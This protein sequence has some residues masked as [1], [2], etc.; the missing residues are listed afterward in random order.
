MNCAIVE[1][2]RNIRDVAYWNKELPI[3]I[4]EMQNN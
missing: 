2:G 1:V 3:N 4:I